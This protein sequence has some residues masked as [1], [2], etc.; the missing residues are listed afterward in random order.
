MIMEVD[1]YWFKVRL[2]LKTIQEE[3][4]RPENSDTAANSNTKAIEV[5]LL[6][7]GDSRLD[8]YSSEKLLKIYQMVNKVRCFEGEYVFDDNYDAGRWLQAWLD[9]PLPALNHKKPSSH[10]KTV[11]WSRDRHTNP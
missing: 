9:I 11:F 3:E 5:P 2:D 7:D 8:Q 1:D 6:I 4:S 10:M